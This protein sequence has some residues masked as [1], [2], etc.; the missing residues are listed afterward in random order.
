MS[1]GV[2]S[3]LFTFHPKILCYNDTATVT[4]QPDVISSILNLFPTFTYYDFK[5]YALLDYCQNCYYN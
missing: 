4:L 3:N 2:S 1:T 5:S